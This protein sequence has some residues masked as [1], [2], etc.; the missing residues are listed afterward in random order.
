MRALTASL[1]L[2][3]SLAGAQRVPDAGAPSG[4]GYSVVTTRATPR[5]PSPAASPTQTVLSTSPEATVSNV[6]GRPPSAEPVVTITT[7]PSG[8]PRG[9]GVE[10]TQGR[11]RMGTGTPPPSAPAA[12][13]SAGGVTYVMGANGV[14]V[15]T[16]TP[17]AAQDPD[18]GVDDPNLPT[19]GS[20]FGGPLPGPSVAYMG[21]PVQSRRPPPAP[22]LA[23]GAVR[24]GHTLPGSVAAPPPGAA[25][26]IPHTTSGFQL[27]P[28]GTPTETGGYGFQMP[29][30]QTANP[31]TLRN[32]P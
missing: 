8:G 16:P 18:A 17:G 20:L 21:V 12:R 19:S 13:A 7:V 2:T 10:V 1:V 31:G 26:W 24:P 11:T 23:P 6:G 15:A 25:P 14:I 5:P 29:S 9:P 4:N 28:R 22:P 30:A 3:T 32:S 27:G